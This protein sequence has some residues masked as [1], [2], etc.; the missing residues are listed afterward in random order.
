[1]E[2]CV[3]LK[4]RE[5]KIVINSLKH[6]SIYGYFVRVNNDIELYCLDDEHVSREL[7][8][9]GVDESTIEFLIKNL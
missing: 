7:A 2:F 6:P 5:F 1:M 8:E 4:T 3:E 9:V